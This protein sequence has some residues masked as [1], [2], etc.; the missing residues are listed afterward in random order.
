VIFPAPLVETAAAL[1]TGQLDLATYINEICN[2]IDAAEPQ[3]Q[4]LLPEADR[5]AR[6]LA[7]AQALQARF[8][9]PAGRPPLYGIPAGIKDVFFV[10]G[11]PTRAGSQ[12]P[13]ELFVEPEG[14]CVRALRHAGALIL[15]KTVTTEFAYFEPGP[16]RNPHNLAYS[17]GGS[18]SGSAAAVAAGFCPLAI[19][20][21][22]IGSTIRPAAFCGIVGFK[23]SSRRIPITGWILSSEALEHVGIFTQNVAGMELAASLLC[24]NW[25]TIDAAEP[26]ALPVLGVPD[27]PYLAQAS[28]E[29]LAAFEKQLVLL[30]KAGYSVRRVRAMEDIE[31]VNHRH[32]RVL[33]AEMA[34]VHAR[35]FAQYG[36]LYR[37]RT[38]AAIREGQEVS[39]EELAA[40]RGS[41]AKLRGELEALMAQAG[42]DLWVCPSTTGPAPEGLSS[43][44]SPLM[45]LP[46]THAGMPAISLPAGRAASGLPLGLQCVGAFMADERLLKWAAPMAE[47]IQAASYSPE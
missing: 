7:E 22:V 27:G 36:S 35:W 3:L 18:S 1:R 17:P 24:Q 37:P 9:E 19:G 13:P 6:L 16:T 42:I 11:F 10:D 44:G 32:S 31:A 41:P 14:D 46:W 39:A 38:A 28:P 47:I 45:N 23:S 2:R 20:T 43:T 8:P 25:Q 30:E 4:A 15:G 26:V 40:S 33:F 12:L 29:G 5:R 21:Q 34:R